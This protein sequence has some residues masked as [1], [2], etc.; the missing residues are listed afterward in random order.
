MLVRPRRIIFVAMAYQGLPAA[1]PY[2][3][4]AR[5]VG[6]STPL[7]GVRSAR[8][9]GL[10]PLC[11]QTDR[12][13]RGQGHH[14]ACRNDDGTSLQFAPVYSPALS[15]SMG[16]AI[17]RPGGVTAARLFVFEIFHNV[18][19]PPCRSTRTGQPTHGWPFM[20]LEFRVELRFREYR[21][22]PPTRVASGCAAR[23]PW[24]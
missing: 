15:T 7:M 24:R 17:R 22:T 3:A 14:A 12:I 6:S 5:I 9:S 16:Y 18:E 2:H 10:S 1:L 11:R 13:K 8:R 23:S 20:G 19:I 4:R 21:T